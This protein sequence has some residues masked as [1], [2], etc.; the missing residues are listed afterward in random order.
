MRYRGFF[1]CVKRVSPLGIEVAEVNALLLP[2]VDTGYSSGDLSGH[3]G[4][5][6]TR[7]LVVEQDTV[8]KVHPVSLEDETRDL[9]L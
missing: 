2:A 6:S 5:P 3:K 4:R 7:A 9:N 8:G 1:L